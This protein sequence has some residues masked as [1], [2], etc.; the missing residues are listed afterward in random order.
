M[1]N[2]HTWIYNYFYSICTKNQQNIYEQMV[3]L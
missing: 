3:N 2:D 1:L